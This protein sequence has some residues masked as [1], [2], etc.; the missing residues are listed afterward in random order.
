V[1]LGNGSVATAANNVSVGSAAG[2]RPIV[3]QAAGVAPSDAATVAQ[4]AAGGASV[5]A[6][7]GGG[8]VARPDG[9][10][11][12]PSYALAGSS[13]NNVGAALLGLSDRIDGVVGLAY[14]IRKEERRGIAAATALATAPMPS[15]PGR[16]SWVANT[17]VFHG[18]V[19][20]GGSIAHRF[21]TDDP[22]ALTA[23][24]AYSK[25]GNSVAKVGMA[26]EF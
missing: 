25:G 6:A 10:I 15:A 14:D 13:Y 19:G 5:A 1:A 24:V 9:T 8:S 17:A 4:L 3:K 23:G 7:L 18:Q 16:T 26:G 11:S 12:A 2:H 21:N 22:L 20:F